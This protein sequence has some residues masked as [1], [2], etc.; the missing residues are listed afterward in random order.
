MAVYEIATSTRKILGR[1]NKE[2]VE[3]I[4]E[5][6]KALGGELQFFQDAAVYYIIPEW[7]RIKKQQEKIRKN[8]PKEYPDLGGAWNWVTDITDG[9]PLQKEGVYER[10]IE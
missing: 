6:S 9:Y 2:E 8:L 3:E 5:F 7:Q 1:F 10:R 4:F